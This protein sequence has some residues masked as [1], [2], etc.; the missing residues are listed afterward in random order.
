MNILFCDLAKISLFYI[1][2]LG[3]CATLTSTAVPQKR[4]DVIVVGAGL[5]GLTVAKELEKAKRSF[6]VLEAQN[7]IGGRTKV[8]TSFSVPID[9]GACWLH[10]IDKNPLVPLVKKMG[11][12]LVKTDLLGAIYRGDRKATKKEVEV[13]QKTASDLAVAMEKVNESKKDKP[14]S[15]LLPSNAP[16]RDLVAS[17]IGPLEN[18]AEIED[19]SSISAGLFDTGDDDFVRE[20]LGSFV[21]AFGKDIPVR[22]NSV[23]KNIEYDSLGVTVELSSGERF[24]GKRVVVTVS[25][26]VLQSGTLSFMPPLPSWKTEAIKKLPMGLLNKVIM[27]FKRDIFKDTPKNSWVLWDGPGDDNIAFIIR[28]FNAPIAIA[29][30]GGN[31]ARILEKNDEKALAHAKYALSEMYGDAVDKELT[32]DVITHWNHDPWTRGSYTY[33]TVGGANAYLE[34]LKPVNDRV[35]FAGEACA[36]P[37][38]NASL[39]GA[40]TSA[41]KTS[42]YLL[43]SLSKEEKRVFKTDSRLYEQSDA[44]IIAP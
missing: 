38:F 8:D 10:G 9:L 12:H 17:N 14:I 7:R 18:G 2:F 16:C 35:F 31:Q 34:L 20:G 23:V 39:H 28:P 27:Q 19:V 25:T 37:E 42:S 26:G 6:L 32:R 29:F 4:V 13:C 15:D 22:L 24:Y 30:Y 41:L 21:K 33:A 3:G 43:E 44:E 1:L 5:A 36:V 11:F 40:Y